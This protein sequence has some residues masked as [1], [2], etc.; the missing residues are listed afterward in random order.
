MS[1]TPSITRW[2]QYL[3]W[4]L[5]FLLVCAGLTPVAGQAEADQARLIRLEYAVFDPLESEP[6]VTPALRLPA[7]AGE[8]GLYLLQFTG[9][10]QDAWKAQ[11]E[12]L[13]A[14]LYGYV[15]D[16]AFIARF[17]PGALEAARAL[18]FVNWI[19]AYHPAYRIDAGLSSALAVDA[20]ATLVV[21]AATLPGSDLAAISAQVEAWG[22]KALRQAANASA[23]YLRLSLPA[24][25]VESLAALADVVW[26]EPY[27]APALLNDAAG[28]VMNTDTIQSSL[29]LY[30]A[31]QKVAVADSGLDNGSLTNLHPDIRG[32]VLQAYCL[33]RPSPCD[34][35][36]YVAHGTHV[37]GSVL[38][39]G[40][41]SGSSP[42]THQYSGSYAGSAPEASLIFQALGDA[43]GGLGGIP[44]DIGDLMRDAYADQARIH[45]NSWGS[46]AAGEYT[47][48]AQQ[49]DQAMWENK[50]M[51]TLFAAGN[52]GVDLNYDGV[53]DLD[54]LG[55]PATAK[56]ILTVGAAEN[57]RPTVGVIWGTSYGPPI[58]IDLRA[59]NALG[60]A[61][62]SSRGPADD[63]RVKPDITAPGTFIASTRTRMYVFND[64][65]EGSVSGYATANYDG[66]TGS[67]PWELK[68][69]SAH[70]ATHYWKETVSGSFGSGAVTMLFTPPMD[71]KKAGGAVSLYF[72]HKYSLSSGDALTIAVMDASNNDTL[73]LTLGE[74]GSTSSYTLR[75]LTI[76]LASLYYP[77][78][79]PDQVRIGFGIQSD[80]SSDSQW[81]LDDVRVDGSDWG[82]LSSYGLASPGDAEDEAY[83]MMGGTSM[84]TPLTAGA[85]AVARE[86]L[87]TDR[88]FTNPSAALLK[89]VMI[90]GA[91]DMSP[92]QYGEGA[93]REV[94][95]LRPNNVTGWGRV[96]LTG[97]LN[98]LAPR[99]VWLVDNK[100]GLSTGG[101][102]T[103]TFTVGFTQTLALPDTVFTPAPPAE[104]V[105]KTAAGSPVALSLEGSPAAPAAPE[106]AVSLVLDDG[107]GEQNWAVT[108]GGGT[109]SYQFMW[110]NR[111]TPA[112]GDLP[113]DLE[114]IDVFIP[115]GVNVPTGGAL[116]LVV[117]QDNDS[118][119]SNGATRL[120][121]YNVTIQTIGGW[122]QYTLSTPLPI[123]SAGDVLIGVINRYVVDGVSPVSNP[124]SLDTTSSQNRS[125]MA[126]WSA[127]IPDPPT[128]PPTYSM[129]L[130]TGNWLVRAY[131][132]NSNEPP[133]PSAGPLRV[134]LAWMDYPGT[135]GAAKA[136]VN[137]LDLE[138]ISPNG[139]HY[140]G[141]S[142]VY[143]SGQCL[144]SGLW[145]ACNNVEGIVINQAAIGVWTVIVRGAN[146]P[147]GPQP[148]ALTASGDNLLGTAVAPKLLY[149]P[150]VIR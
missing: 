15:P 103:Y 11:V 140:Y 12:G 117:F 126:I 61:A 1:H 51:L 107:S 99:Q 78:P 95:A 77:F 150:M 59:N 22:G 82:L 134:T 79:I 7:E 114:R 31:G 116:Q 70:S 139:T 34:W 71:A 37:A 29:G 142:G 56:N 115:S 16:Y 9:P 17:K 32:R 13:G 84:A 135:L 94:P 133:P 47:A 19:G 30:G 38:G 112:A 104:A 40:S 67:N 64:T 93:D 57:Y 101:S 100:G 27:R 127:E 125:W 14:R 87:T 23:G 75:S 10:V 118:D 123:T 44:A 46:D 21:S 148:F 130:M 50:D 73:F 149:L 120:G 90:N 26:V 43:D 92:G 18:P 33:G 105:D 2:K 91:A 128:L 72:W 85:S 113:F 108:G 28:G 76:S 83:V 54:S 102:A 6:A 39:N 89:A 55:S 63:G 74:T 147:Q 106:A 110:L 86:W 25:S 48:D 136:L 137:D 138:I 129:D 97:S 121:A 20:A 80:G 132:T 146:V 98:P 122:S 53:I 119:P 109:V 58:S 124:A 69:D 68:T 141:N 60:M 41:L 88:G 45:T 8:A 42:S 96:D 65:M 131:G 4:G 35:S 81:W 144:R 36:D 24:A 3:A 66:G 145:D 62:F 52:S 49:V 143:F 111:F 5:L